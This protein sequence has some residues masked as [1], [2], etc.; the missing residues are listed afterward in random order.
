MYEKISNI[1]QKEKELNITLPDEKIADIIISQYTYKEYSKYEVILNI[2]NKIELEKLITYKDRKILLYVKD[3][4]II[5]DS[6][7]FSKLN[8]K[9]IYFGRINQNIKNFDFSVSE[10]LAINYI[11]YVENEFPKVIFSDKERKEIINIGG[12]NFHN[13]YQ[14]IQLC[15][16]N[17]VTV[18]QIQSREFIDDGKEDRDIDII[19]NICSKGIH[20]DAIRKIVENTK[21]EEYISKKYIFING[22][23]VIP[24]VELKLRYK[25]KS[26]IL[27][28]EWW[29][30]ILSYVRTIKAKRDITIC[31][32]VEF[33]LKNTILPD[34][35]NEKFKECLYEIERILFEIYRFRENPILL[36]MIKEYKIFF[37][38]DNKKWIRCLVDEAILYMDVEEFA[39]SRQKF[40]QAVGFCKENDVE[41]EVQILVED[42]YSR[43]LEKTGHY[44]DAVKKLYI[45][46]QYYQETK[47]EKKLN[48]VKNR[49]GLNLSFIGDIKKAT[50]YLEGLLFGN[51]NKKV[52]IN[53]I[54]SCE[55]ANNLSL[56]YMEAGFYK[57]ALKL[58]NLLY[59]L[60]LRTPD[61]PINYATDALQNKG[62]IY[63]YEHK[64]D[65]AFKCFEQALND[66]TNPVSKELI[67]ENYLYAKGFW[68]NNFE[69]SIAFFE[70]Q[71]KQNEINYETCKMLAE[72]YFAN[73]NYSKCEKFCKKILNQI[74]YNKEKLLYISLDIMYM[75][76][77]KKINK[78]TM[79]QKGRCWMRIVRYEQFIKEHVGCR[80]PYWAKVMECKKLLKR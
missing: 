50:E 4:E 79:V 73:K 45:V 65:E 39:V 59:Q 28:E 61:T 76:S 43:L 68:K 24:N 60:Y 51:F 5:V 46:E 58:Q 12:Y 75:S 15:Y 42:E 52:G 1:L 54:L 21:L 32:Q 2:K 10:N 7:A 63:L 11:R 67:F 33:N 49:I 6:Q 55:V 14:I 36:N 62:S 56:C 77:I 47:D 18:E 22:N 3:P 26:N 35:Q 27:N 48:N 40:K 17:Q 8:L 74:T 64:Y 19:L 70:N 30:N 29:K 53:N 44:Y 38:K 72:M 66:E 20:I 23:Y 57:K 80:S 71:I 34:I 69:E 41:K 13:I 31:Q 25:I 37:K 9:C 78:L 16:F